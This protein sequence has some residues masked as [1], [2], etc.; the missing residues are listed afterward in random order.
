MYGAITQMDTLGKGNY[1][2]LWCA[3]SY[4]IK[5]Y[6]RQQLASLGIVGTWVNISYNWK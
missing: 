3:S 1:L 2:N 5:L 4:S 6:L